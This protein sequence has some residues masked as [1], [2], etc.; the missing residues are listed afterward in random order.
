MDVC[1]VLSILDSVVD[2]SKYLGVYGALGLAQGLAVLAGSFVMAI[3]TI[4][5]GRLL[6]RE[7]LVN[8]LR[9]PMVRCSLLPFAVCLQLA[10]LTLV[11]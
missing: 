4:R 2:N 9:S 10:L 3:G 7:M 1:L 6:H 5:A 11:T 8:I